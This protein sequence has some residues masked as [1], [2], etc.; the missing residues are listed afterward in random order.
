[1]GLKYTEVSG[2]ASGGGGGGGAAKKA[3]GAAGWRGGRART[4][5]PPNAQRKS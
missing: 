5:N 4:K 3:K 2:R 1:M